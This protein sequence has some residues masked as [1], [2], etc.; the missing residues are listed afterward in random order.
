MCLSPYFASS[1]TECSLYSVYLYSVRFS[2]IFCFVCMAIVYYASKAGNEDNK[3]RKRFTYC[4]LADQLLT[5]EDNY[6]DNEEDLNDL[7]R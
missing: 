5:E 1:L 7:G 4:A 6:S 2:N 3:R